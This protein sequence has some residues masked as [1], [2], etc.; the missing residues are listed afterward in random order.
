MFV[1]CGGG[2]GGEMKVGNFKTERKIVFQQSEQRKKKMACIY[3]NKF[4]GK[5]L[6][7]GYNKEHMKHK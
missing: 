4:I 7:H 1:G 3:V 2:G 5:A 6:T